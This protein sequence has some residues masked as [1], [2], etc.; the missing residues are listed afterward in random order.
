MKN[1]DKAR[2]LDW[3]K[4]VSPNMPREAVVYPTGKAKE[5]LIARMSRAFARLREQVPGG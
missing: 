1:A 4:F 5:D 3:S 2:A